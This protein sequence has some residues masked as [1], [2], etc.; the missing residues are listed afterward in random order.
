MNL[1]TT[2]PLS[3]IV[4]LAVALP[5]AQA[6][7]P[8]N[9]R[10]HHNVGPEHFS[11]RVVA[12]GVGDP[13]EITWGPDGYLWVTERTAFR[14]TRFNPADGSAHVALK[15]DGVYQSVAHDGVLGMALD[16]NLLKGRGRDYVY[17]AYTYDIDPGP[18]VT[19]NLRIRRYTYDSNTQTLASPV[20]VIDGLPH[21]DD[22]GGG[23]LMFG[24]DG[25]L[26]FSRGDEGAGWLANYCRPNRAQDLTTAAQVQAHDWS[27]Y[28]GKILRLNTDGSIPN[29][30]PVL[31]GV[32][33]HIYSY[34]HRNPQGFAFGPTGIFYEAEHGPS[35]DDEINIIA[36]GMNYGWPHV[37]GFKDD[38]SYTYNRWAQSAPEPC[39]TLKFDSISPPPSVRR[40]KESEWNEPFVP[41]LAT[42]FTVPAGYD[43]RASGTATIAPS[44][45]D[46]YTSKAIPGWAT[47]VLVTGMRTGAIYRVK[48]SADGKTAAGAPVEYF[49]AATRYR[50]LALHPDGTRIYASTDAYGPTMGDAGQTINVLTNPGAILEFTC[51]LK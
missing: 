41:P 50:D 29:D 16:P 12:T 42:L 37:A 5:S 44:G 23:R 18:G 40:E 22:H 51:G 43:L 13:W 32:R 3:A 47:S 25:K 2:I 45:I 9:P 14:V 7:N 6:P 24:P 36:A 11:L 31:K 39:E 30:N 34:G 15:L 26:Y 10:N 21:H 27:T 48:L 38:R 19:R 33:S 46:L 4:A 20:E 35:T 49:K 28:Q 8:Q 17:V 1:R